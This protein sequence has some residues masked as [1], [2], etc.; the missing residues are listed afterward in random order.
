MDTQ[1]E[2]FKDLKLWKTFLREYLSGVHKHDWCETFMDKDIHGGVLD[3]F[4][5]YRWREYGIVT[6]S[7]VEHFVDWMKKYADGNFSKK[8]LKVYH[9]ESL[10]KSLGEIEWST[11]SKAEMFAVYEKLG[12]EF[13]YRNDD[14]LFFEIDELDDEASEAEF[15]TYWHVADTLRGYHWIDISYDELKSLAEDY[16]EYFENKYLERPSGIHL[17]NGNGTRV[18]NYAL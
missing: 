16:S 5:E 12:D 14:W 8:T 17:T 11:L 9:K 15:S 10:V 6:S 13:E 18:E 2:E 3:I 1:D 7:H 4:D